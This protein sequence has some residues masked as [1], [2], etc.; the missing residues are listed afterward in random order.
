MIDVSR[1]ARWGRVAEGAGEDTYLT[2]VFAE[3]KVKGFQGDD[4]SS[5]D[6]IAA[7][8]KHLRHT[9]RAKAEETTTQPI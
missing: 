8:A 3:A 6:S 1:D 9:A 5:P 4:L 7:C 2:S